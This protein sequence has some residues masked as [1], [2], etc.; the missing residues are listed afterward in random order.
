MENSFEFNN[1]INLNYFIRDLNVHIFNGE[2]EEVFSFLDELFL[3][4]VMDIEN[5]KILAIRI[6][7]SI[8]SMNEEFR[9]F[10]NYNRLEILSFIGSIFKIKDK[11]TLRCKVI[12]K[13]DKIV[14][15]KNEFLKYSPIINRAIKYINTNYN[16]DIS[17]KEFCTEVNIHPTYFG[18]KFSLELGC[19]F[20]YYLNKVRS[21]RARELILNTDKKIADISLEVGYLDISHFYKIFKK[22]FGIPPA[23]LREI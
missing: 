1:T 16:K 6:L 13:L 21:E 3:S 17:I 11:E 8:D 4:E 20:S 9:I 14:T 12:Y 19:T 7:V 2:K 10:N 22:N 5:L 23:K 18:R 15:D